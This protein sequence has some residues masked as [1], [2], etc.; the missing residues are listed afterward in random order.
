[1]VRTLRE[2]SEFIGGD[3]S[4]DGD[5]EITGVSGIKEAHPNE[6]T[7]VANAK[8]RRE[9]EHTR[10]S[11]IIIGP[12]IQYNG[13]ASIRV[14]DPYLSFVKVL[15]MFSWRKKR[16]AELGVH[17]TAIVGENVRLGERVS[18]QA[19]AYIGDNVEIGDDTI[20]SPLVYIGQDTKIGEWDVNLSTRYNSGRNQ[21]WRPRDYSLWRRNRKRWIRVCHGQRPAS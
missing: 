16:S 5:L 4:G 12:D 13:K 9:M 17:E 20:I 19:N 8:Y 2:I 10:A 15:E 18:I 11:A 21:N 6:I 3:L 14:A 7:F 1:M